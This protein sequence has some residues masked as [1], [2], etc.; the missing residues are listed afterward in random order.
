MQI[1]TPS[2]SKMLKMILKKND[3]ECDI[4][5]NG[6]LAFE[7]VK[8]KGDS[9]DLIFMDFTMPIMVGTEVL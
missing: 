7:A 8:A 1:D 6:L 9:Y 2:N 3:I 4:A 5:E